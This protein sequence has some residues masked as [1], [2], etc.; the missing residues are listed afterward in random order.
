MRGGTFIIIAPWNIFSFDAMRAALMAY[1][2]RMTFRF[3]SRLRI[4]ARSCGIN[5]CK[6]RWLRKS[7][8]RVLLRSC[9]AV[10]H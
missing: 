2:T 9:G 10:V 7:L 8:L 1:L 6:V 3:Y 4:S 5:A